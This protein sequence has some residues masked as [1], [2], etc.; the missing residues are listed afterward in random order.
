MWKNFITKNPLV[1][2][3]NI[4]EKIALPKVL[5]FFTEL[6][7]NFHKSNHFGNSFINSRRLLAQ[8]F[9][10]DIWKWLCQKCLFY[11]RFSLHKGNIFNFF[12]QQV[13]FKSDGFVTKLYYGS[14]VTSASKVFKKWQKWQNKMTKK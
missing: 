11:L 14:L 7:S 12:K 1:M 6:I 4:C 5:Y 10:K 2:F 3:Y 8:C 9:I 13:I